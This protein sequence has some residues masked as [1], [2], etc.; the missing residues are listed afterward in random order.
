M[1]NEVR[2]INVCVISLSINSHRYRASLVEFDLSR[3]SCRCVK[4]RKFLID[5]R[6]TITKELKEKPEK[7]SRLEFSAAFNGFRSCDND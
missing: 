5:T 6:R 1:L 7:S 4:L 3:F 2:L